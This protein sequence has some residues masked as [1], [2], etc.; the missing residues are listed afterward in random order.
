MFYAAAAYNAGPTQMAR[1]HSLYRNLPLDVFVERIP[2]A[3]TQSYVKRVF[4]SYS[5]YTKLYR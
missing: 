5:S 1:W 3:E 4:L 2:F